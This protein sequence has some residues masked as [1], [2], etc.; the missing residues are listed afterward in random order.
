MGGGYV[1]GVMGSVVGPCG[2]FIGTL[3]GSFSYEMMVR[4]N[5]MDENIQR[6]QPDNRDWDGF[7]NYMI[8]Y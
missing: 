3:V 5:I 1:G 6:L 2:T 8:I 4:G 7:Y